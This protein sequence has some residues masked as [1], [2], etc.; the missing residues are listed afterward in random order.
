MRAGS[1]SSGMEMALAEQ[2]FV[3]VP[4]VVPA[5]ICDR[6]VAAVEDDAALIGTRNMLHWH[7][8]GALVA[9]IRAHPRLAGLLG[10]QH[11]AVQCTY[12]QKSL[13]T[14]WL[15]PLHQDLSIPVRQRVSDPALKG[16]S[17][18]EG[19]LFVQPPTAVLDALLAVRIHLDVC[20]REDGPLRV[21]PGSH[22]RGP[23]PND[24]A[25]KL[26]DQALTCVA[27]RGDALVMRP[28][29]LHA[30][31]H[32]RGA[33]RRRVLHVLFGPPDL[34]HGLRWAAVI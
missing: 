8:A 19:G 7:G 4:D 23:I 3:H 30:S 21:V 6:W 15:V 32:A 34:P 9:T 10:E 24:D 28:L 31:S 26:R 33:G 25:V 18:K 22:R 1:A 14:N 13:Q 27:A 20:G 17:S 11:V 2:G 5:A 16:W 29:L 12:F